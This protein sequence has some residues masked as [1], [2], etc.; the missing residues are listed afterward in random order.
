MNSPYNNFIYLPNNNAQVNYTTPYVTTIP[1]YQYLPKNEVPQYLINPPIY[2]QQKQFSDFIDCEISME[3]NIDLSSNINSSYSSRARSPAT[4]MKNNPINA[5][6]GNKIRAKSP[7]LVKNYNFGLDSY[8]NSFGSFQSSLNNSSI[9]KSNSLSNYSIGSYSPIITNPISNNITRVIPIRDE[10]VPNNVNIHNSC[11]NINQQLY[12]SPEKKNHFSLPNTLSNSTIYNKYNNSPI[13]D[14][15]K[16]V[17]NFQYTQPLYNYVPIDNSYNMIS[18]PFIS[19]F[20]GNNIHTLNNNVNNNLNLNNNIPN[21]QMNYKSKFQNNIQS[22]NNKNMNNKTDNNSSNK[23]SNK[24]N[25]NNLLSPKDE[26]N[27]QGKLMNSNSITNINNL[28]QSCSNTHYSSSLLNNSLSKSPNNELKRSNSPKNLNVP[29]FDINKEIRGKSQSLLNINKNIQEINNNLA[30]INSNNN[31]NVPF[32]SIK[33]IHSPL[34]NKNNNLI[35]NSFNEI[36]DNN[37][38]LYGKPCDKFSQYMLEQINKIR[39]NPKIF[40]DILKKAKNNIRLDK[41]GNLYYSGKIKVALYKGN[42]AFD[43]AIS[44]LE[45]TKPMKPLAYKKDLCIEISKDKKDFKNG[46]Y[47][48][49]KINELIKKG[50]KVRAFWRDII[51]DAETNFLLMIVDDNPIRRG[52]KRK[53]VLNPEMKYIGII[54]G[55]VGKYFICYTVLSDE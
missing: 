27:R 29:G 49:K 22:A 3:D 8:S 33:N 4:R 51:S 30:N 26:K 35:S 6:Y 7:T 10:Y 36:N 12:N 14:L 20:N 47:L 9:T 40:V 55:I 16:N 2:Y 53:D 48:R 43:E 52:E 50:I 25:N 11:N 37:L 24:K 23:N 44:A 42:D 1:Q 28:F 21:S 41:K 38:N 45:K 17:S 31:K 32:N 54:S 5:L 34:T 46:D 13:N 15:N 18:N 39:S 19:N